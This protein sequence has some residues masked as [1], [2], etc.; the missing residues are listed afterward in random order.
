MKSLGMGQS[1]RFLRENIDR[2][3]KKSQIGNY[4]LGYVE[5]GIFYV[6]YVGRSDTDLNLRLK[7][8]LDENSDYEFFKF[9][10]AKTVIDAYEMECRNYHDF[11][12]NNN[13]IHPEKP[14]GYIKRCKCPVCRC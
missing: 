4:A 14:K 3:V 13:K 11:P 5:A 10:F 1:H 2:F 7:E 9:K 8:H 6:C 12:N